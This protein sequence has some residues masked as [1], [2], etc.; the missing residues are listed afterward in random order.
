MI[1]RI[2]DR[3][4]KEVEIPELFEALATRLSL[5]DLQSL[6]LQVYRQRVETITPDRVLKQYKNNRFV[7]PANVCPQRLLELDRLAFKLLPET[8]EVLELSPLCPLGTNAVVA[9]IDQNNV[10][11]TIRNT[12]VC[13]DSTNVLALE[14]AHRRQ[15]LYM[16]GERDVGETRLC[17][18]HRLVRAQSFD[19]PAAFAHFRIFSL[20]TAGR[21][22]GSFSFEASSLLEHITFYLDFIE[23]SIQQG[24]APGA[25]RVTLTVFDEDQFDCIDR[26]VMATLKTRYPD[27]RFAFDQERKSGRGYYTGAGFQIYIRDKTDTELLIVDG[28]FTDWTQ[29]LLSNRKERLLISGMGSERY[30]YCFADD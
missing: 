23:R 28:G 21:D 26:G 12:E 15:K 6:L 27:V 4:Q 8:Y 29:Q 19:E 17:S 16:K 10:V 13:S 24:Y 1:D 7:Q 3:I 25:Q 2:L 18:S 5:S 20:C 30:V 14:C 11:S 22:R 9:P